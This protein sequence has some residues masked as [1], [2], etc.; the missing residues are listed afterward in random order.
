MYK[1][2]FSLFYLISVTFSIIFIAVGFIYILKD[3]SFLIGLL[4]IIVSIIQTLIIIRFSVAIEEFESSIE[5]KNVVTNKKISL[6]LEDIFSCRLE[7][8]KNEGL[9]YIFSTKTGE[10][11]V[12]LIK[13][14]YKNIK[15]FN[16][17]IRNKIN[18]S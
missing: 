9:R 14:N 10:V 4:W 16:Q 2:K 5:F 6:K 17:L 3:K 12:K 1:S 13:A 11:K 7:E 8:R 15:K 18:I